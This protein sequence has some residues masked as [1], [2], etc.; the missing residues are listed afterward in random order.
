MK[1]NK[2]PEKN[3]T[4]DIKDF[5]FEKHETL[6]KETN[7]DTKKWKDTIFMDWKNILKMSLLL[8]A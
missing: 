7:G 2:I 4:K 5:N 8:K 6:M 1:K 3:L